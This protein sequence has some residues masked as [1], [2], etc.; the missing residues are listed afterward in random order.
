MVDPPPI[1][2]S[3]RLSED[4]TGCCSIFRR[5]R[6]R[7]EPRRAQ[8][9]QR[10]QLTDQQGPADNAAEQDVRL[11]VPLDSENRLEVSNNTDNKPDDPNAQL[12]IISD[13]V[14]PEQ[15]DDCGDEAPPSERDA[16]SRKRRLAEK[17]FTT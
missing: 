6:H 9:D 10:Q 5:R 7:K 17:N 12:E 8:R 11:T 13:A 4:A 14:V 3:S 16:P 15:V 2:G 1:V